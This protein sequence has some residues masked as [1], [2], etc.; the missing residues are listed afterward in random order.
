MPLVQQNRWLCDLCPQVEVR[1]A[2]DEWPLIPQAA[3]PFPVEPD[4]WT[5]VRSHHRTLLLCPKHKDVCLMSADRVVA[6]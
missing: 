5:W 3:V 1:P 4:G 6:L 2:D